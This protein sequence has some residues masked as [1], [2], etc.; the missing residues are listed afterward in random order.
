MFGFSKNNS[1]TA[2]A[3]ETASGT[4][5]SSTAKTSIFSKITGFVFK[6][7][8]FVAKKVWS[9]AKTSAIVIASERLA[10]NVYEGV[11]GN[12]VNWTVD[13]D[14][15]QYGV[16][17]D[18]KSQTLAVSEADA[19]AINTD[20]K[21]NTSESQNSSQSTEAAFNSTD[22]AT[23]CLS[24]DDNVE[25]EIC[26]NADGT[27]TD[28]EQQDNA[29][30][31]TGQN[32]IASSTLGSTFAKAEDAIKS[33]ASNAANGISES[34]Q[35]TRTVSNRELPECDSNTESDFD[36]NEPSA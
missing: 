31:Q 22:E 9:L 6:P 14:S 11:T 3:T 18:K 4:K 24:G 7:I 8:K 2:D 29:F 16:S 33:T 19:S 13:K 21:S 23:Q 20:N 35:N 17:V 28:I 34:N 36:I 27:T 1:D 15:G 32:D 25:S 5:T 26:E 30:Q 10:E 12:K